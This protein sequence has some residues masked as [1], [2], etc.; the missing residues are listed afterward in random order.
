MEFGVS[1]GARTSSRGTG[2]GR[3]AAFWTLPR[4]HPWNVCES[5]EIRLSEP[6]GTAGPVRGAHRTTP[7]LPPYRTQVSPNHAPPGPLR[8][9]VS[10][11]L[12]GGP[13]EDV[14][15][16][17]QRRGTGGGS[18]HRLTTPNSPDWSSSSVAV[19]R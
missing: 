3:Q 10:D 9:V 14:W 6:M 2:G 17:A 8:R 7:L 5:A 15:L 4:C 18:G 19:R 13:K 11:S 16:L 12:L 1:M